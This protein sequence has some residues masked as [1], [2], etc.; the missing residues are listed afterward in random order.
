MCRERVRATRNRSGQYAS[1]SLLTLVPGELFF[2]IHRDLQQTRHEIDTRPGLFF[3]NTEHHESYE[4]YCADFGP[5]DLGAVVSFCRELRAL[6][7]DT[8]LRGRPII[9]YSLTEFELSTNAAFL[10]GSYLM[11]T[12]GWTAEEAYAPFSLLPKSLIRPFRDATYLRNTFELSLLDCFRGLKRGFEAKFFDLDNFDVPHFRQNDAKG[13]T[14]VCP[15]FIAFKSPASCSD[16]PDWALLPEEYI[17]GFKEAGVT[18]I[19]RFN[20]ALY[21]REDFEGVGLTH[22]HLEFEDCTTPSI[23]IVRAFSRVVETSPGVIAVHCLAGL[24][25]TGTLIALYFMQHG[26]TA[27]EAI[28]W[29]RVVRPG[30]VIGRQQH[31]LEEVE[32]AMQSATAAPR[33]GREICGGVAE[34]SDTALSAAQVREGLQKR[35]HRRGGGGGSSA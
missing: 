1:G 19:V 24:G 7:A 4:A 32:E 27:R 16:A 33:Y 26:W 9:V 25:R 6:E 30:S 20:E 5:V 12:K 18:D 14:V 13:V 11:L 21:N 35:C 28:G 34:F 2:T 8:R 31:F 3:W 23:E 17:A 22:H 10:L 29:L 15:R